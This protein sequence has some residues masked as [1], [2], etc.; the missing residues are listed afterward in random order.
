MKLTDTQLVLL[1][2][3]S[4]RPDGCA[5]L[6]A[7]LKGGA[8]QKL[9]A[10]LLGAGLVEEVRAEAEMPVWRKSDD[11]SFALRITDQGL[12]AI[13]AE[14]TPTDRAAPPEAT[15]TV[16]SANEPKPRSRPQSKASRR[17]DAG[18]KP[19]G[20][21]SSKQEAVL[22]LLRRTQGATIANIMKATDWQ[23]HSVRGFFAGVVRKKLR[24]NLVSDVRGAQRV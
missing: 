23:A 3:A 6:P 19:Q 22:G 24:L 15:D 1:S 11:G 7:N 8:A 2:S 14:N 10:K 12:T 20:K 18:R 9:V 16:P 21:G 5:E 4:Q 13:S 17:A